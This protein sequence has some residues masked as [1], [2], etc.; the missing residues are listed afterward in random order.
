MD[1]EM[2]AY[3]IEFMGTDTINKEKIQPY[4]LV[5]LLNTKINKI[6]E[7]AL[8]HDFINIKWLLNNGKVRMNKGIL[9]YMNRG[10]YCIVYKEKEKYDRF[11]ETVKY[12]DQK[13]HIMA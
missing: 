9:V 5:N 12:S 8:P 13:S 4:L 10:M 1:Q 7:S 11:C 3:K 6:F 2:D